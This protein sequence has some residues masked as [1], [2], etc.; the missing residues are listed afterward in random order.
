MAR[1]S[2]HTSGLEGTPSYMCIALVGEGCVTVTD[3]GGASLTWCM[4][5]PSLCTDLLLFVDWTFPPTDIVKWPLLCRFRP[6]RLSP[7]AELLL[8]ALSRGC[9]GLIMLA[10]FSCIG[11]HHHTSN[12]RKP[13]SQSVRGGVRLTAIATPARMKQDG[14]RRQFRPPANL[15]LLDNL[16]FDTV[17]GSV[18][19]RSRQLAWVL[20]RY[21]PH[22]R[23][24]PCHFLHTKTFRM[25]PNHVF[26]M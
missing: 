26:S 16:K 13:L 20:Q 12:P 24:D 18:R 11:Y 15:H 9:A 25:G 7:P 8:L 21:G 2:N 6:H 3:D 5:L 14:T 1:K 17:H 23:R 22:P 19:G 10:L 4:A